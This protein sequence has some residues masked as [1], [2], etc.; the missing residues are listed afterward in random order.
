MLTHIAKGNQIKK[1]KNVTESCIL[2]FHYQSI[3]TW[4]WSSEN[5]GEKNS[6]I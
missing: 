2:N 3:E 1:K 4:G 6:L 5:I